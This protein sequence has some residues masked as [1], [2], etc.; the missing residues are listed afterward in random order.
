DEERDRIVRLRAFGVRDLLF[1]VLTRTRV[2]DRRDDRATHEELVGDAR[3]L[4]EQ[5]TGIATEIEDESLQLS[6]ALQLQQ[7][8]GEILRRVRLELLDADVADPIAERLRLDA[9][10]LDDLARELERLRL[11]PAVGSVAPDP[12]RDLRPRCAAE[13][14][15]GLVEAHVERRLVADLH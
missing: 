13:M 9:L 4:L 2:T 10:D 7:G 8:L 1:S 11:L 15:N 3:R 12:D 5:T 6:V 14:L